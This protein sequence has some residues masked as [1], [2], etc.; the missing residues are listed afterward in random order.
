MKDEGWGFIRC[1]SDCV[2][3]IVATVVV[4]HNSGTDVRMREQGVARN[5]E[6]E[7]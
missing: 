7:A 4:F 1:V 3:K 2:Q 5:A 6:R